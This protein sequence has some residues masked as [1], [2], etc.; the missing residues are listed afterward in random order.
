MIGDVESTRLNAGKT[1]WEVLELFHFHLIQ[2][3]KI[4]KK[5]IMNIFEGKKG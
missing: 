3:F 4:F 2:I 5:L 1:I